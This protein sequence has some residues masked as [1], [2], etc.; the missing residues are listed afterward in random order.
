M[1][2]DS[3]PEELLIMQ[4]SS[5]ARGGA[6][7]HGGVASQLHSCELGV[8][9]RRGRGRTRT[10]QVS[11]VSSG[12][13]AVSTWPGRPVCFPASGTLRLAVGHGASGRC[14]SVGGSWPVTSDG[15]WTYKVEVCDGEGMH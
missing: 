1:F 11:L 3:F 6:Q 5:P 2:C 8:W 7:G 10:G 13:L 15:E 12:R 4:L 9:G 14:D